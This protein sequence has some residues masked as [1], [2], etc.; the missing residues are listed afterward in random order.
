MAVECSSIRI[1]EGMSLIVFDPEAGSI[2][3]RG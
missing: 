2:E 3:T 1:A